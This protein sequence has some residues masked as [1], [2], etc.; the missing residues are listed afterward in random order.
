MHTPQLHEWQLA[1]IV[2]AG[3]VGIALTV[4]ADIIDKAQIVYIK[5]RDFKKTDRTQ[6]MDKAS[7]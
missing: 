3:L 7:P 5:I 4:L 6:P 2:I 1:V